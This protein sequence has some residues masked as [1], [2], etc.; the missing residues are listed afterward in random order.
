MVASSSSTTRRGARRRRRSCARTSSSRSTRSA[1]ASPGS[2]RPRSR[3]TT[4]SST[5]RRCRSIA[6][7]RTATGSRRPCSRSPTASRGRASN[8]RPPTPPAPC[9]TTGS[10]AR[11]PSAEGNNAP[12]PVVSPDVHHRRDLRLLVT[13]VGL[14]SLGDNVALV[15]LAVLVQERG[16]SGAAVAGL[17]VAL[18]LPAALL[19]GPAG[20]LADRVDPRRVLAATALVAAAACAVMPLAGGLGAVLALVAV[21]GCANAFAQ[22]AEFALLPAVAGGR[23]L[24][25]A[26]GQ[27]EFARYAGAILGPVAGGLLAAEG[28]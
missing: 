23:D 20:L 5:T 2:S 18:W 12:G 13:A 19:A 28:G 1:R 8:R 14:S 26:N 11:R 3:P 24:V 4:T 10:R 25:R 27:V 6:P 21:L 17:F 7:R 16:G 22:P 9:A 15:P